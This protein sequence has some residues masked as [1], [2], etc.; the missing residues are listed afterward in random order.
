[1]PVPV[2]PSS[3]A[4]LLEVFSSI[5]GEGILAGYRQIFIRMAGCNLNCAYCD[6]DFSSRPH[7]R[8]EDSPGSGQFLTARN[9]VALEVMSGI[10]DSWVGK[11]AG[12]HHSISLTGGEPLLQKT[13]LL[14]WVPVLRDILPLH[15]ETNGTCPDALEG[16]LPYLSWIS[17]DV[18]LESMSGSPTP[19]NLHRAFLKLASRSEVCVKAVVGEE[20]PLDEM[21]AL[22][23]FVHAMAPE[24]TIF[25]QPVTRQNKV[26]V[27]A[28][29][30][31]ELQTA[32]AKEH[33]NIRVVPQT[34][35]FLGLL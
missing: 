26:T 30:L 18:K 28:F 13:V 3:D 5:Q 15:L 35:V 20:T 19:W 21:H 4:Q 1:M 17:M 23:R 6:T 27:P 9:P 33:A 29:R 8:I 25:L 2:I 11:T 10:L 12:M 22:G 32:L 31:L 7:C 16:L 14:E 24:C 34:H